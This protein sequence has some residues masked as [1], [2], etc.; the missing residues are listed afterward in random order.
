MDNETRQA[1]LSRF[2]LE[3]T[4]PSGGINLEDDR[5]PR[6]EALNYIELYDSFLTEDSTG[7]ESSYWETELSY[8]E[9]VLDAL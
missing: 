7:S 3:D 2:R 1:I 5:F 9:D 4:R 6:A 8:W